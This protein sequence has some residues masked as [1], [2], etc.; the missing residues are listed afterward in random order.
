[1]QATAQAQARAREVSPPLGGLLLSQGTI[2]TALSF[3]KARIIINKQ[4]VSMAASAL[5]SSK[6]HS[7]ARY[8]TNGPLCTCGQVDEFIL[9]KQIR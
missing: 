2:D 5:A 3:C 9:E 1:M 4:G 6:P 7:F 8:Q